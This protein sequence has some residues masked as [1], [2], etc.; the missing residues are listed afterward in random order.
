LAVIILL[1]PKVSKPKCNSGVSTLTVDTQTEELPLNVFIFLNLFVG[2]PM[3]VTPLNNG[4]ILPLTKVPPVI[5][6][7]PFTVKP[8][9]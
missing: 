5:V 2:V 3:S 1:F 8:V 6:M 9:T 4:S 7:S